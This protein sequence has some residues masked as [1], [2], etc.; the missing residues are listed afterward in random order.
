MEWSSMD[1]AMRPL[2][3]HVRLQGSPSSSTNIGLEIETRGLTYL[4]L[5]AWTGRVEPG[6]GVQ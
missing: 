4:A 2:L 5:M 6:E 1:D 3:D